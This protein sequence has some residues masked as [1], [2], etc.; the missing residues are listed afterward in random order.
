MKRILTLTAILGLLI[1]FSAN[2][3]TQLWSMTHQGGTYNMGT[4]FKMNL[5]GSGYSIVYNFDGNTGKT[6]TGSLFKAANGKLYGMASE[7]GTHGAGVLFTIDPTTSSYTVVANFDTIANGGF[8]YGS[9]IQGSGADSTKLFGMTW[10]G[11]ASFG[12]IIFSFVIATH[13]LTDTYDFD[14]T[15]GGYPYGDLMKVSS[16]LMYGMTWDGNVNGTGGVLFSYNPTT[17]AFLDLHDFDDNTGDYPYGSLV[18]AANGKLYGM[19]SY[20]GTNFNGVVFSFNPTGNVYTDIYDFVDGNV[21]WG[22]LINVS[23]KLYGMTLYGGNHDMGYI[24]RINPNTNAY[25]SLFAFSGTDGAYPGG[26]LYLASTGFLYGMTQNGGSGLGNAFRYDTTN[27]NSVVNERQFSAADGNV[28]IYT[29]FI[30]V[31]APAT[32]ITTGVVSLSICDGSGV[33]VLYT[34]TGV[35]NAGNIFTAQLSD[36]TGS[37]ASPTSI[38]S[39]TSTTSGSI[40]ATIP[41]LTPTGTLYRIRV[42]SSNPVVTGSNNGSNITI[43]LLPTPSIVPSGATTFCQGG[44]VSL[45]A[46]TG[47][48]SYSWTTTATTQII[49]VSTS[50]TFR[51]TVTDNIGCTGTASQVVT[52]NPLPI[53]TITPTGN[54]TF[55]QGGSVLLTSSVGTSYHWSTS[56]TTQAITVAASGNYIVTVTNANG[57]TAVSTATAVTVNPIPTATITPTGNTTFCQGGSVVLTASAGATYEWSNGSTTQAISASSAGSYSVTITGA[58]GCTAVSNPT[59]I[60]VNTNPTATITPIGSTTFCQGDSVI[61]RVNAATTYL[62]SNAASTQAI[63]AT[64]GGNY[65]VTITN[66]SGCTG[67][68]TQHV[69]VNPN[70]TQN[71][72]ASICS[73]NTYTFPDG[74]TS[75]IATVHT[76]LLHTVNACDSNITTTLTVATIIT[77]NIDAAICQGN[78]YTFPDGSSSTTATVNTSHFTTSTG[79]DSNIVTSLTVNPTYNIPV[80]A[81]ICQGSSYTFPDGSS[82]M[83]ATVNTSHLNTIHNCDS[84]IVTTLS[85]N[86]NYN[87]V[88]N[89]T[90]CSGD[91]YVFPDGNTSTIATVQTSHLS[92]VNSCDSAIVTHLSIAPVYAIFDTVIVCN[93]TVYV[94]PDGSTSTTS[95]IHASAFHSI[96]NCDSII[97]IS[98]FVI[99]VDT[100]VSITGNTLT[101]NMAAMTYQWLDCGTMT[102][103]PNATNQS[104]TPIANGHYAVIITDSTCSDT[105]SC[106]NIFSVGMPE[107]MLANT[108]FIVPNPSAGSF[109]IRFMMGNSAVIKLKITNTMG[110]IILDETMAASK[111]ILSKEILENTISNGIYFL[112]IAAGD[113]IINKKIVIAK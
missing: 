98:L 20:G 33:T 12:G 112:N 106:Y 16:G 111:G 70:Y 30:E 61:L 93:G 29:N 105:S 89:V 62:W 58:N 69:I 40:S 19:T 72:A 63:T 32:S 73:G 66:N 24:F 57:C 65:T 96:H 37:F 9:L 99:T 25:D 64:T 1:S 86:P 45:N 95:T 55:C 14:G 39:L 80:A 76:S 113:S 88:V 71:V 85:V 60:V 84:S 2:A 51:V 97:T 42:V 75:T 87:M 23:N 5:D 102:P 21:P 83:V 52:V 11:G 74:S 54:T 6:P 41:A 92:T 91:T 107:N 109:I 27:N 7:G 28:P 82:S 90:I 78:T 26:S 103:I 31:A 34:A 17:S 13:V 18:Q 53:A 49:T 104:Y 3:Q 22:N 44:S 100:S 43:H 46:G 77:Q 35:F 48:S 8:P 101:A 10:G 81:S 56:A 94:F 79:C 38:G 15:T 67:T 36:A 108:L 50:N 68:T 47:Y 110:D 4:V 59:T